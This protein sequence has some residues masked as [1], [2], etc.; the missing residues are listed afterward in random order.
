MA[1]MTRTCLCAGLMVVFASAAFAQEPKSAAL[2]RQ[3]AAALDAAQLDSVAAKDPA[4]TD[5]FVGALYFKGLQLLVISAKYVAPQALEE[6][7][8]KKDYRDVYLDLTSASVPATKIF[9]EDMGADGLKADHEAN[10]AFDACETAGKRVAFDG[11][12]KRQQLSDQDY[13]KAFAAADEAYSEMLTA[14]L[15]QVKKPSE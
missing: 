4:K 2:A 12:A 5:T 3:L 8:A 11:D 7:V 1:A 15:A 6:K 9:V 10:T 14:L 13:K